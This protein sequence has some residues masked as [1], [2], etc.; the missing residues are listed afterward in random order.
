MFLNGDE[1][2]LVGVFLCLPPLPVRL[3]GVEVDVMS[4]KFSIELG[5]WGILVRRAVLIYAAILLAEVNFE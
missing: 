1:D 4:T 2:V 5:S 3:V